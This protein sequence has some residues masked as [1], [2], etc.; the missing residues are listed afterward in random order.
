MK[1]LSYI[2]LLL[3][4]YFTG[5]AQIT[6]DQSALLTARILPMDY[7]NTEYLEFSP[8]LYGT[9]LLFVSS[10]EKG[11]F[12]DKSI[13]EA[14]FELK[15]ASLDQ[16]EE[17][18][19]N[20]QLNYQ[21]NEV[22]EHIGP[23]HYDVNR[24]VLYYT[25]SKKSRKSKK[26]PVNKILVS[27]RDSTG[28]LSGQEINL[29]QDQ[30]SIQHP[31]LSEDGRHMIFSSNGPNGAGGYDLYH[32]TWQDTGWSDPISLG[33]GINTFD[34][35]AF[36]FLYKEDI[37]FFASN[38]RGGSGGY[39]LFVSVLSDGIWQNAQ[40]LGKKINTVDDDFGLIL[41]NGAQ[42]G[43][44]SSNRSGGKGKDDIYQV[45]FEKPIIN[46]SDMI[47]VAPS[48][49]RE[50]YDL[51]VSLQSS[52]DG[53][54]IE[55]AFVTLL[56]FKEG[57]EVILTGFDIESIDAVD[58]ESRFLMNIIPKSTDI[59]SP[60]KLTD[61][62]GRVTFQIDKNKYYLLTM[63]KDGY[64]PFTTSI[65]GK[66]LVP[67]MILNIEKLSIDPVNIQLIEV[68]PAVIEDKKEPSETPIIEEIKLDNIPSNTAVNLFENMEIVVFDQILYEYGSSKIT[69]NSTKQLDL[70]KDYMI[71]FPNISVELIAHTDS[72]GDKDF[73]LKLSIERAQAAKSYLVKKGI[74]D[75]RIKAL[76]KGEE[77]LRNHCSNGVYCTEKE[78]EYNRRTEVR[79][80]TE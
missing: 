41:T 69:T 38:G 66:A 11:K 79:I 68:P 51:T 15:Y 67:E 1:K 70:L 73:N 37:L 33:P 55:E 77:D 42:Q 7:I 36:P 35:E 56:P 40:N 19:Q 22:R 59:E 5:S 25:Q 24:D 29:N 34:N 16:E 76:G 31:T 80:I 17:D 58:G 46:I 63:Q 71:R 44:F 9:G 57:D 53:T 14:Y 54:L 30:W 64:K 61:E 28:W 45:T 2:S 20:L 27:Q 50:Y 65:D 39:D 60:T 13:G 48:A 52:A 21:I 43:Y 49:K 4:S 47:S 23:S 18:V 72:R 10:G 3:I 8:S 26:P 75:F 32:S 62:L 6:V 74:S 12:Y 78:H